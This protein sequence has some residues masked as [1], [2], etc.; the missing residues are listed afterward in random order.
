MLAQLHREWEERGVT[1]L[2]ISLDHGDT[3]IITH[4]TERLAIPYPILL[5]SD[6]V[7]TSYRVIAL[8][9][10]YVIDVDGMITNHITGLVNMEELE[11]TLNTQLKSQ[12]Q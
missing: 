9:A 8:P 3:E 2:G 12:V 6:A 4:Y 1:V 5:G 7:A 11:A 10:T